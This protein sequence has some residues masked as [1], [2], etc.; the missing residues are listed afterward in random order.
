MKYLLDT[1]AF[2]WWDSSSIKLSADVFNLL[3][4]K[5]NPVYISM[6][7]IWEMQIKVQLGKLT[8]PRKLEAI[9]A[10]QE[11]N[12]F[13]LLPIELRHIY[14]LDQLP[15]HHRDPFDRLLI[16][17]A[18]QEDMVLVTNDETIMKYPVKYFWWIILDSYL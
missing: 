15:H 14:T 10:D 2:I 6:A 3:K 16:A 12:R 4:T 13:K 11:K 9:I 5:H 18:I 1:M 17:Q 8:L 7:S